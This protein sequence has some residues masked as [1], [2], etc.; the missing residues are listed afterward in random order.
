M[1]HKILTAI[2]TLA[3]AF[4][5]CN[6][7]VDLSSPTMLPPDKFYNTESDI[8]NAVTGIYGL[9]R[10]NYST[11]FQMGEMPSDNVETHFESEGSLGFWDKLTWTA[12]TTNFENI[13]INFYNTIGQCN[14][15]L[16]K[17]D[18]VTFSSAKKKAQY[19]SELKF[20]R[21]LIYF[22]LVH[23][24]GEIPLVL[25]LVANDQ[26]A[27]ALTRK[28]TK[29]VYAQIEKD[30][31][32]AEKGLP[33]VHTAAAD[34]GRATLTA[35]KALL[36]KVY[37]YQEKY[38]EAEAKLSEAEKDPNYGLMPNPGDAFSILNEHNR[39]VIF[40][41]QYSR[42]LVGVGE[43]S[44]F[45]A[46]FLPEGSR[47][48]TVSNSSANLGTIDLYRLFK[49]GDRR[50]DL[51]GIWAK[52]NTRDSTD[53]YFYFYTK[54]F[55]DNPP[56]SSDGE[57]NW[58]VIR[59]ADVLLLYAE[60]LN[61][62]GKTPEAIAQANKVRL[63]AGAAP[64]ALTLKKEEV[65]SSIKNERR[66]ELCFEGHRWPDLVRWG[67]YLTVMK[68]FK[69]KYGVKAMLPNDYDKLFPIPNRERIINPAL[70]QNIGY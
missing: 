7:I 9:L 49:A 24:F 52:E 8:K 28:P 27:F 11:Y 42:V 20:I 40:A 14:L 16:S 35:A 29:E 37:L 53:I 19:A 67:D 59:Y 58:I 12:H 1:K 4:S 31:T 66:L 62:Q 45:A 26:Q 22:E 48:T 64:L 15:V 33:A 18:R 56:S 36:G 41:V 23:F 55:A 68:A 39:E 69:E 32:E 13:W 61:E 5:S 44:S 34:A 10:T 63:R 30:L 51:I 47:L 60:A 6:K 50:K 21:A 65:R 2:I 38:E 46:W 70:T 17:L 54:K 3:S 57:N 25:D 43:G